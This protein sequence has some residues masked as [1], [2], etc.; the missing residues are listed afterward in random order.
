MFR[1]RL[2]W[3]YFF[4]NICKAHI[5]FCS[6]SDPYVK[7]WLCYGK[8][9]VE[10]KKTAIKMRTLN[11]VYN[12]SFIFEIPWDKIREAALEVICMDF[13]KVGRNEMIG[14]VLLGSKSGPLENRH[15]NDMISKPRQQIAQWHLLKDWWRRWNEPCH[16]KKAL[17]T[18]RQSFIV[19]AQ[20]ISR[21]TYLVL[22]LVF[23]WPTA[24]LRK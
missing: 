14:K 21:A 11:P 12:E 2:C 17:Q 13:D 24:Y 19:H 9:K 22:W 3:D 23:P 18:F 15:W 1:Y 4:D 6:V 7:I 10:K 8:E 16:K 5:F 20:L